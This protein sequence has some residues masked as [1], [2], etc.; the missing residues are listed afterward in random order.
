[1]PKFTSHP[2]GQ[3][4]SK[5]VCARVAFP[6]IKSGGNDIPQNFTRAAQG[7]ARLAQGLTAFSPALRKAAQAPQGF[8]DLMR[9][10]GVNP[11]YFFFFSRK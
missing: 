3:G 2:R 8:F 11:R 1:M 6:S 10:R 4:H 5:K 9:A 7:C